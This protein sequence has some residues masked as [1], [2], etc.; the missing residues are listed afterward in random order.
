MHGPHVR[1]GV[2]PVGPVVRQP[3]TTRGSCVYN[4]YIPPSNTHDAEIFDSLYTMSE[5]SI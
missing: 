5:R 1:A 3:L 4:T 2:L